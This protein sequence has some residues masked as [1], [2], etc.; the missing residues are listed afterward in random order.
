GRRHDVDVSQ[1][2]EFAADD[3]VDA[4][5]RGIDSDREALNVDVIVHDVARDRISFDANVTRLGEIP[6][7]RHVL[8]GR[9]VRVGNVDGIAGDVVDFEVL[10]NGATVVR[11]VQQREPRLVAVFHAEGEVPFELQQRDVGD[12]IVPRWIGPG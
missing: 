3:R 11:C 5:L 8:E 4:G 12:V 1:V 6:G 2:V 7:E 10:D 9:V